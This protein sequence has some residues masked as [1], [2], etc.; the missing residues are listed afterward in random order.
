MPHSHIHW[1]NGKQEKIFN[2]DIETKRERNKSMLQCQHHYG[3]VLNLS[4]YIERS[5]GN[6][7]SGPM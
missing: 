7:V 1:G 2:K 4:I 3:Q 6:N 5:F